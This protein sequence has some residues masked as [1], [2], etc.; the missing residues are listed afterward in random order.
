M[1]EDKQDSPML[2]LSEEV[3]C[4]GIWYKKC[5]RDSNCIGALKIKIRTYFILIDMRNHWIYLNNEDKWSDV[6]VKIYK[7]FYI[8]FRVDTERKKS[9][10]IRWESTVIFRQRLWWLA[11]EIVRWG[12]WN[13]RWNPRIF[14]RLICVTLRVVAYERSW[15]TRF[16][17]EWLGESGTVYWDREIG[18]WK[19][20]EALGWI[21]L[22]EILFQLLRKRRKEKKG[23]YFILKN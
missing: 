16:L 12:S 5:S 19:R 4:Y 13:I 11:T 3:K 7:I 22:L 23:K 2:G 20:L 6:R 15:L 14:W 9:R 21:N 8:W 17:P 10:N 18:N 1:I